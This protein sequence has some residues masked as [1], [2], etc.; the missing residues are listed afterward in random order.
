MCTEEFNRELA[1][2]EG[3]VDHFWWQVSWMT[4]LGWPPAII[5]NLGPYN[6][7]IERTLTVFAVGTAPIGHGTLR[8]LILTFIQQIIKL[9][10]SSNLHLLY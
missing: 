2:L 5:T 1:S 10:V 9:R 8:K 3:L 6:V 4:D 7:S